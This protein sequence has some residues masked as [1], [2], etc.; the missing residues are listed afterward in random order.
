MD[1]VILYRSQVTRTTPEL[2]LLSSNYH[3]TPYQREEVYALDR[4]NVHRSH[5]RR[6]FSGTGRE[7][8]TCQPQCVRKDRTC[9]IIEVILSKSSKFTDIGTSG[10]PKGNEEKRVPNK[11][12]KVAHVI[13]ERESG[14]IYFS[15]CS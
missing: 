8:M 3:I 12:E 13:I 14:S 2:A 7:L 9:F 6:V 1:L 10:V 15:K 11:T 5:K 4:F